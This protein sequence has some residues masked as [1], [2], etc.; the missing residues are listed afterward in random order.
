MI[1]EYSYSKRV[2]ILARDVGNLKKAVPQGFGLGETH[3]VIAR[4][5]ASTGGNPRMNRNLI[6]AVV[7]L[8][9]IAVSMPEQRVMAQGLEEIIVTARKREESLQEIPI[10]ITAIS[11]ADIQEADITGLEDVSNL[12]P[13][14]YF[15]NQGQNQPGRYNTQLRFRGLN[16][17]QFS[18]SFETGAL[19]IDG[20]YVL[21]GGTSLSMMDIERIEVI[22]GPQSAYFGRNTFGGAVNF[23][24]RDPSMDEFSGE[25]T[26]SGTHRSRYDISGIVE[27]PIVP[28]KLSG[29]LSARYYDKEGH[30]T[31]S[32]GGRLGDENTFAINGKL[33]WQP[34][35][36][37]TL[38]FRA[39]YAEDDDGPPAQAYIAGQVNDSCNG[40]TITTLSGETAN[41]VNFVCGVVPDINSALSVRGSSL[42]DGNTQLPTN[43]ISLF[44][45]APINLVDAYSNAPLP[46]GVPRLGK[47]G[48]LRETL[49]LSAHAEYEINDYSV[50]FVFGINEQKANFVRDFDLSGLANGFSGDP[51]SLEDT[52]FELRLTSPQENRLRWA[53]GVNYYEQEFTSSLEG[54][55][56][57]FGCFG[58]AAGTDSDGCLT[59]G[60]GGP[61]FGVGPFPNTFRQSDEAEVLGVFGSLDYDITDQLTL[62]LEGRQQEDKV[63]KG[64]APTTAGLA[65][66]SR[67]IEFSKFLPRVI[68]RF[69]PN[70]GTM[71]YGS[72]ALGVVPGDLNQ[73]IINADA[74]ERAQYI[75]AFP[76]LAESLPQ[77]ELDSIEFGWKQTLFDGAGYVNASIYFAEWTGIK[78]RSSVAIN[79]TCTAAD[80]AAAVAGC[81]YAGVI[82]DVST[83]MLENPPGS[84]NLEILRNSRNVLIDGDAD[85]WG[86]ELEAGGQINDNWSIDV[87]VAYVDSEYTRYIYNF[88]EAVLGYSDMRG[89]AVPRVPKW[90]SF[91]TT[92]YR[93][94]VKEGMGGFVRAD[95]NY[96]GKTFTEERNLNWMADYTIINLRGGI[97]T[98]KYRVE[99]FANNLFDVDAWASGARFSDT[100]FPTDFGNFFV[101]QGINV[102]P[103]DRVEFGVRAS[104][105]F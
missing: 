91:A 55:L 42:V 74:Q 43:L 7:G 12:A 85:L 73:E 33:L 19:F 24:T 18:P 80:V 63:I 100:A 95:L 3:A 11:A 87:N 94:D 46:P 29:S 77:E 67:E 35:D 2:R 105:K 5:R 84:G 90:S 62:T 59:A 98:D 21:N 27:G 49:R 65:S 14:F 58:S 64:G 30:Y 20:V 71:L 60:P 39:A 44:T 81:T 48:L 93:F 37:L 6:L 75:A 31:A 99:L 25:V 104:L 86:W 34:T 32:D 83:R 23:I 88:G 40:R 78:G 76:N 50:D 26:F 69:E 53:V 16:Q 45:G 52:S 72:Y 4:V 54:G 66:D 101:Q 15:F 68:L 56:F 41:P 103:N 38:K 51:Q 36:T 57:Y 1:Y 96:Y 28:G 92:T 9:V 79:E 13:G 10:A 17:A 47:L 97:E 102:A 8:T 61:R 70:E 82:P 22:K 89:N